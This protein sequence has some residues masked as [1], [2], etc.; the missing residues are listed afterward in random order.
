MYAYWDLNTRPWRAI[1]FWVIYLIGSRTSKYTRLASQVRPLGFG[2]NPRCH[3]LVCF[4]LGWFGPSLVICFELLSRISILASQWWIHKNNDSKKIVTK[5]DWTFRL[6]S[7]NHSK[8]G[9]C[10]KFFFKARMRGVIWLWCGSL[11]IKIHIVSNTKV[12]S[13]IL[14][15]W[16]NIKHQ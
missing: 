4:K 2:M 11:A 12:D 7:I 13:K 9:G 15:I 1:N 5:R 10:H 8:L 6:V 14:N 3:R 16:T